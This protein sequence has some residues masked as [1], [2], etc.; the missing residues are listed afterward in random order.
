MTQSLLHQRHLRQPHR[1]QLLRHQPFSLLLCCRCLPTRS[2]VLLC[3]RSRRLQEQLSS[4]G[5]VLDRDFGSGSIVIGL[6]TAGLMMG[7]NKTTLS[8]ASV[9]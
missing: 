1:R 6:M 7:A 4:N 2:Q 8:C 5:A 3:R 9:S